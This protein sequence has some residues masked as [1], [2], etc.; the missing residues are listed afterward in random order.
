MT[1][2]ESRAASVPGD[3]TLLIVEDDKSFLQ[4]LARAMETRGFSVATAES[5]ADG[6]MQLESASPAFAV[7]DMRLGD[8]NGLEVITALKRRRPEPVA[9]PDGRADE[10]RAKLAEARE[11]GDDRESFEAGETPVDQAD[12]APGTGD[13]DTRRRSVHEQAR[14]AIDEMQGD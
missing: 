6:L 8:G 14:A 12:V 3:R 4:R 9:P 10:L 7:V 2:V 13:L 11:A 5:V 1:T